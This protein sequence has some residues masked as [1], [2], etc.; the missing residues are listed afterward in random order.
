MPEPKDTPLSVAALWLIM[1]ERERLYEERDKRY[2]ERFEFQ[3][4]TATAALSNAEKAM[5]K[6]ETANEK[7]LDSVNEFRDT[8]K[9]QQATFIPRSEVTTMFDSLS[10]RIKGTESFQQQTLG[11]SVRSAS[12]RLQSNWIIQV[13]IGALLVLIAEYFKK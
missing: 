7:R 5:T 9:D 12:D 4:E 13:I 2:N 10:G 11:G 8:L 1:Q 6:A 3:K